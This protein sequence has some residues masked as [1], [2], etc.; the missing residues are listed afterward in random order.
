MGDQND[1]DIRA[2]ILLRRKNS[3]VSDDPQAVF[4]N[5][6]AAVAEFGDVHIQF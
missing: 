6:E 3:W 1:V 4:L 5:K 2:V